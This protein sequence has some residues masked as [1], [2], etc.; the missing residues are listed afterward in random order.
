M[1]NAKLYIGLII[2][3]LAVALFFTYKKIQGALNLGY[4]IGTS[5]P[6]GTWLESLK[7]LTIKIPITLKNFSNQQYKITQIKADLLTR[8]GNTI[9]SQEIPLS[10]SFIVPANS[11][12]II[13]MENYINWSG[14]TS[15]FS[16]E[17]KKLAD[18]PG[19]LRNYFQTETLG[20]PAVLTG[21]I[22]AEGL[23]VRINETITL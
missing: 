3:V 2:A 23:Q 19:M 17:G 21:F 16:S 1:K 9:A 15:W 20:I 11:T 22:A 4:S 13:E 18:I 10:K 7:S 6:V 5:K 14:L 8:K 12:P